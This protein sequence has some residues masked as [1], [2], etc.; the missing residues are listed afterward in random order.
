MTKRIEYIDLAKGICIMLVVLLHVFGDMSGTVI[1]IMNLFRMPL[2]FVLSGLF[3]KQYEGFYSFLKKKT[4]KLLI[5]FLFTFILIVLPSTLLLSWKMHT[6]IVWH[7]WIFDINGKLNLG[8][9]G[10]IWFLLCL[11][12]MNIYFYL[13]FLLCRQNTIGIVILSCLCGLAGYMLNSYNQYLFVW[14]DSALTALPF[15]MF[16]YMMRKY[17]TV[18][19]EQFSRKDAVLF[20]ASLCVLLAVYYYNEYVGKSVIGFARNDYNI[21]LVSLYIGGIAGT[22]CV[23]LFSKFWRYLPVVSYVGRYS[24]VVLLTH[25]LYLFIIRNV[26]YQLSVNQDGRVDV[27]L[28][29]FVVIIAVSLPTIKFCITYLPYWFAQKDLWK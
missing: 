12:F 8:I 25:L 14:M 13:I 20:V 17:S 7:D 21:P 28:L 27:N 16:G 1:K 3:F 19:S 6:P 22:M 10:T 11:F 15:F 5:P 29:V 4:N 24:I 2:Y 18:L 23:L 26:L 9:D